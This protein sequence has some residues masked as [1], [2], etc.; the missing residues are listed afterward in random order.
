MSRIICFVNPLSYPNTS[1]FL[2]L[3]KSIQFIWIN[4]VHLFYMLH[5]IIFG[6]TIMKGCN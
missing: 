6:V 3:G 2:K 4:E 5:S 1:L